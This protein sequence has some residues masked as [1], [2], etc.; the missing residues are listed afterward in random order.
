VTINHEALTVIRRK[1]GHT[2]ASLASMVEIS[3]QYLSDIE[4]GRRTLK[5]NPGLIKRLASAL[6]VPTSMLER[7]APGEDAA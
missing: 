6:N 7:R 2:I 3:P 5:R 4:A 1:D